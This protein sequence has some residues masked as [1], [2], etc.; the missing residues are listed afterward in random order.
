MSQDEVVREEFPGV[1]RGVVSPVMALTLT[2][3]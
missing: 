1:A 2:P 3:V